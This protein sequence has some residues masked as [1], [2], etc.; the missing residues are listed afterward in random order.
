[1]R[2]LTLAAAWAWACAASVAW[3]GVAPVPPGPDDQVV[4]VLPQVTTARPSPRLPGNPAAAVP[5]T[6]EMAAR[7]AREA[8]E[9]A[10]RTGDARYWDRAQT[11]LAAWWDQPDAPPD[12]MVLQATVLQGQH[13]FAAA[14]SRLEQ[15]VSRSPTHAQA[16]LTLANLH[17]LDGR[18]ADALAAC[19]RVSA[20]GV[21]LYGQ[22]CAAE[23]HSLRGDPMGGAWESLQAQARA[24]QPAAEPWLLSLW[25]EHLERQ[26]QDRQAHDRYRQSLVLAPDLYTALVLADLQL[27]LGLAADALTTLRDAPATDAVLLRRAHAQRKLRQ[28]AWTALR[29]ELVSRQQAQSRRG[30]SA[31]AHA[32]E[33]GLTALWLLDDPAEAHRWAL[34]NLALQKEAIDWQL[35]LDSA[36]QAGDRDGFMRLRGQLAGVGLLDQRLQGGW[37]DAR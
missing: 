22:I 32:R 15:V 1:M 23:V 33:Y 11:A 35:A 4:E 10:R 7:R 6:P 36:R 24:Q 27:R 29:D 8:I 3:G 28:P 31:D 12:V 14:R 30:E 26:G 17:K 20:A 16:W 2:P 21:P 19:G 37:V 5:S 34:R 18:Y 13:R 25:G 9:T